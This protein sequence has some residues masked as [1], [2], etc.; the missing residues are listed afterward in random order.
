MWT[1]KDAQRVGLVDEIGGLQ[2]AIDAAAKIA[3]LP[4]GWRLIQIPEEES[5]LR[6]LMGSYMSS[7]EKAYINVLGRKFGFSAHLDRDLCGAAVDEDP[8]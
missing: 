1:G 4:A 7:D 2:A 3:E 6:T 5:W 8:A